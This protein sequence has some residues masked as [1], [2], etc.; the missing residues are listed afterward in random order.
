MTSSL[1]MTATGRE[2]CDA[3]LEHRLHRPDTGS[4]VF[5][6]EAELE[7]HRTGQGDLGTHKRN[8][9]DAKNALAGHQKTHDHH[10]QCVPA[11]FIF[12]P[13]GCLC[14]DISCMQIISI[15]PSVCVLAAV[16]L[17]GEKAVVSVTAT[18]APVHTNHSTDGHPY[19]PNLH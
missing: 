19:L 7:R 8:W 16:M 1:V 14:S 4:C 10:S 5:Q 17:Q 18:A 9:D 12:L 11:L 13:Q 6:M 3:Q 2:V 15:L